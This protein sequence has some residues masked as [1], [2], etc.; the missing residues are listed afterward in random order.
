MADLSRS[1]VLN[2]F[3][4]FKPN[5]D[6]YNADAPL[7]AVIDLALELVSLMEAILP[8]DARDTLIVLPVR[9]GGIQLE[10]ADADQ[11]H[12]LGIEPDGSLEFLHTDKLT[13]EMMEHRYPSAGQAVHPGVLKEL[14]EMQSKPLVSRVA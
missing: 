10:W 8:V 1:E 13:G 12:E 4:T 11:E 5:W 3:R 9:H 7:P 14:R 2:N 6:G